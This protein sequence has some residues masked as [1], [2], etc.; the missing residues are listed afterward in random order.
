PISPL[1]FWTMRSQTSDTLRE[2]L[3]KLSSDEQAQITS[4]MEQAV[5]EF[6]PANRMCFP[7]QMI[8]VTGKKEDLRSSA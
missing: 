2:K 5:K 3:A 6:F 8:V 4:E 1:K 7:A